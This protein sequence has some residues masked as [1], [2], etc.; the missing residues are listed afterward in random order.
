MCIT[1][2]S[3][4]DGSIELPSTDRNEWVI[5]IS[6]DSVAKSFKR[7]SWE[8]V[9]DFRPCTFR[10]VINESSTHTFSDSDLYNDTTVVIKEATSIEPKKYYLHVQ[11][12]S[13]SGNESGVKSVSFILQ[14]LIVMGV[15]D[16]HSILQSKTFNWKC[17][18]PPCTCR[19]T[20]NRSPTHTFSSRD[21]YEDMNTM[22]RTATSEQMEKHYLHVQVKD[23]AGTVSEV[24]SVSFL[25]QRLAVID[26]EN[27]GVAKKSKKF[28]WGC[29]RG[30]CQFRFAINESNLHVF[31]DSKAYEDNNTAIK[32][33]TTSYPKTYY[34]HVQA[35][36]LAGS[37]SEVKSVSFALQGLNVTGIANDSTSREFKIFEWSCS[38]APCTYRFTVNQ[39]PRYT[40]SKF[41]IYGRVNTL[42]KEAS[43]SQ[44]Q[45]YYLHV[46]AKDS[47]GHISEVKSVFFILQKLAVTGFEDDKIIKASKTL[48]WGCNRNRCTYRYAVNQSSSHTFSD[49]DLYSNTNVVIKEAA[50]LQPETYYLHVQ[51][52]DSSGNESEVKSGSFI[53]QKLFVT[54]IED[55]SSVKE[56]KT[57][58]WGCNLGRC[59]FRYAVTQSLTQIFSNNDSY[60]NV[61]T[62]TQATISPQVE[63]YYLHVQAKDSLGNESDIKSVSFTLR[64]LVVTGIES[65]AVPRNSKNLIWG[66]NADSC[67]F[68]F[69]VN[70][71]LT[72]AFS[73][74]DTY[75]SATVITRTATSDQTQT[76]YLHVQAKDSSGIESD[77]KSVSFILQ[78]L[79]VTGMRTEF[80]STKLFTDGFKTFTWG[81]NRAPCTFR[82]V[83]NQSETHT[84]SSNDSYE[85]VSTVT[86]V[87]TSSEVE[88]YYLHVQAKD[89][90]GEESDVMTASFFL[91]KLEVTG[92]ESETTPRNS[93][94]F[95]WGCNKRCTFRY[96]VN[97]SSTHT[98]SSSDTYGEVT[99]MERKAVSTQAETYYLHV[100][101][102]DG[103][104]DES[105]VKSVSFVLEKLEVTGLSSDSVAKVSKTFTWSCSGS[106]CEYRFVVNK[107]STHTFSATD[108]YGNTTT[109]TRMATSTQA[110]TYYL[111]V[112]AK[113][114]SNNESDVRS[115]SFVLQKLDVTGIASDTDA[116]VSKTFIWGCTLG[117][118]TYR[119]AV[120][121][122]STHT[123]SGTDAYGSTTTVIQAA[124]FTQ[125]ETYYLH[126]QAKDSSNN[127][128]DIKS[129]SFV[130]QGLAVIGLS[131]DSVAKVSKTFTWDCAP[132]MCT[133]RYVVNQSSTHTFTNG[134][135]YG[136]MT[137][138]TRSAT[139][140]QAETY[141]LH[142]QAKDASSNESEVKSVSFVLQ[143][144]SVTGLSIDSVAK[145]SKTFAWGCSLDFCTY[146]YVVN[147]SSSHTFTNGDAYGSTATVT[148]SATSTQAETYYLHVQAKDSSNNESDVKSVSFV[149][150][151]LSVTGLS[152]DSVAKVSKTFAWGCSLDFCTYRYVVNQSS[153]HTFTNGDAYG[154]T[155]TVTRSAT[156]TQAETYY[157][158]VQAKDSSNNES[159]VKSVSFVLQRLSVTGLSIDSVAK[160]SKTF[161]WN[162]APWTC[163][164]RYVV[165]QSSTHTFTNGDA[166]GS[167]ATVTRSATSTQAETYYLHVQAKDSLNNESDVKSVSFVL[168]GLAVTGL[169]DDSDAKVSKTFAWGCSLD[170]CT[171]RYVVNQ[172]ST[173]TFSASDTYDNIATVTRTA[174]STQ[175]ETYYLH[176]QAKDASSN[177]SEVKT[178]SFVLQGLSVI[179]IEDDSSATPSK[180]FT[181]DC[182]PGTC[183]YRYVVNQS[184]THTFSSTDSYGIVTTII[185][186]A[187]STQAETYY[188]H[189][190]AKDSLNNE[191]DVKS[192][193]FVLQGLAV[194]DLSSDSDAK[195]SKTFTWDCAPG[196]CTYRYVVN[197][198]S[199]HTFTNGDA[200]GS[201]ATVTRSATSTQ[202]ETYYLHVQAKDSLN[203]ESDVKS[204]SFVLQGLAV[205]DLSSD[206][207]AKVSK[208]FTWDCAPGTCTYRYVVNQS[209]THT[210]SDSDS[211]GIVTTIIRTASSAQTET[212][213]L[214]VQAKDTSGNESEVKSVLFVLQGLAVTGLSDDNDVKVSKTFTWDCAPEACTYRYVVNQSSTHTFS[215]SDIYDSTTTITRTASSNTSETYYL[216]VQAKDSS[217]NESE[218]KSVSFVLQGLAVT[219]LSSDSDAKVSKT[220]TWD[221]VPGTCT[222]RY[223]VNQSSTHTFS[224][225]DTYD[226]ITTVTRTAS[227]T[228]AETYYLHIQA[229]DTSGNESEVKSVSFILQVL[230]VTGIESDSDVKVSKTF[231]WGCSL[232][233]CT[234]RYVVNQSSTHTFTNGD[235][236]G[237]TATVTRTASSN[238]SETYYLHVQT[239]DSSSNES[240]VKSVSFVLQNLVVTGIENDTTVR[241]FKQF[242]WG[243]NVGPCA[244]RF[245]VGL[246]STYRFP[247]SHR[248]SSN[249]NNGLQRATSLTPQRLYLHVQAKD[250]LGNESEVKSVSFVLQGLAVTDLSSDS[251]AKVSK[252]F[253]W[254]CAPGTCTYRYVVN[255]SSSHTF[256]NGDA[257]GST[258]TVTRSATS[259]QAET[260]YLHVQAKDSLNNESDV[261]SVSF[262]LQGLA[263]INIEDDSTPTPSKTFT[264]GCSFDSCTYRYVVNQSSTHTFSESDIYDST[265]MVTRT[266]TSTQSETYYLHVQSKD[267]A[268]NVSEVK[269]VSFIL[270]GL[271]V[272]GLSNDNDAKVSK[273]FT[274]SCAPGTCTYRYVVN[275][276]STHTFT[277]G[278]SYGSTATVTRSATSIQAETY[279]LHVQ[280][281]DT[282]SNESEV[283]TVSFLLQGLSVIDIED[284][285]FATS[286]KIFIWNCA[287]GTCTYRYVVNQSSTHTFTNGDAYGS[288]ATVTR[289]ATSTQAETYYLHVQAKDASSNESEVKSVSFVLQGL[290]VTGIESDN[291]A[292]ASKTF[293][294]SCE[295]GTCTYRYA[296]NQS[297]THTFTNG[298]AYGSIATATFTATSMQTET[299]Y[300]HVQAK[301]SLNNESDVKSVLFV[302]QGLA[303]TGIESDTDA[304]ASKTFT[305]GCNLGP[306][307][308]RYIIN[309]SLSHTFTNGDAYGS[310]ETVTPTATSTQAETYYLHV[311]VK[312]SSNH[313]SEVKTIFFILQKLFVTGIESDNV[314]KASKTFTWGCNLGPCTF[315]YAVNQSVTH[316]FSNSDAYGNTVTVTEA[317]ISTQIE[318][319]YLHV[320]AKDSSNNESEVKSVLFI[321]QQLIVEGI[322]DDVS[323]Q[324]I[325][326]FNWSCNRGSPCT[327]R[328]VI[329]QSSTHMFSSS[330][331]Y[332]SVTTV[333]ELAI[334]EDQEIYYLHVQAKDL[335]NNESE[336]KSVSFV[337]QA[338][339][340]TAAGYNFSCYLQNSTGQ[341]KCWGYNTQGQLGQGDTDH[342]GIE[343]NQMGSDLPFIDLGTDRT[344]KFIAANYYHACA[345]LDNDS[346]KCWGRNSKGQL[347]LGDKENRGD[348]ANEMGD[349]LS[350][351]N[352]GTGRTAKKVALGKEHTCA[353]LDNGSVKCWGKNNK[354]QL[355]L[356]DKNYRGDGSNKM[357]DNL[358]VVNLG[359]GRTA[360]DIRAGKDHTCVLL[361]NDSLKCWGENG[362]GQLGLGDN[363]NRG[364]GPNE[365]GDNLP[366]VN[367]GANRIIKAVRAGA[368]NTCV[369]LQN[370]ELICWGYN[371][372]GQLGKGH[373][374]YVGARPGEIGST[375]L[376]IDLGTGRTVRRVAVGENNICAILDNQSVKCWGD[377]SDGG[378]GLGD[379]ESRGDESNE[380][381]DNLPTVNL[382]T[383]LKAKDIAAGRSHVCVVLQ[384]DGIKCWGGGYYGQLGQEHRDDIGNGP[385]EMGDNLPFT[386]L[387]SDNNDNDND[388]DDDDDD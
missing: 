234:Y 192:V 313:E 312:N 331:F 176:V 76:Y 120:N 267:P 262:V 369:I 295:P 327:Y 157:L 88:T 32:I 222:Y 156:S 253:T 270:Q 144:L 202:A 78:Q 37:E 334:I 217:S 230:A 332:S 15:G 210:F 4:K 219:D 356:G 300:L 17:N 345:I 141:Y 22:S 114:L 212:Y 154:S 337:L 316:T 218:V 179:N 211:Y 50:S 74:R 296:V 24:K 182:R 374:N 315:R 201:T 314:T 128:S 48:R 45:R 150:Q 118:C 21:P 302:L 61:T 290:S 291:V 148:R 304:K 75:G 85:N 112:Q 161:T 69:V 324:E 276:S 136:S 307:T 13:E 49:R 351:V 82:F 196:T 29:N 247:Q 355:G 308:Y 43:S 306:C 266:A 189:V 40:F 6:N 265:T 155:A 362:F 252:T 166:Y 293:N 288:T 86:K 68:R 107:S 132:W 364:D 101:A 62:I 31:S 89:S 346:L 164:Y 236:Y 174:V 38:D 105:E 361:D 330:D 133:Y 19:A 59:T 191:S 70:Q 153:S 47:E 352:L 227:S 139:S 269:T 323:I 325:K 371:F 354:G 320:Q 190:Q 159:D 379:L 384:D 286:S 11:A 360:K 235:A 326:T 84:F 271:A 339:P 335:S 27:D 175:A 184:S 358:P 16:D 200:Y 183:T 298:D 3:N 341:V 65:D 20:I 99:R 338:I 376:A 221:C 382:G 137:T 264:W 228:Q 30:T 113:D 244:F 103:L 257:Y 260:Y 289:S 158:H 321:L 340:S 26:I 243:C 279:Y 310:T 333:T 349:N 284:D 12:R 123:F 239:K 251:D 193:S 322:E 344:V 10:H 52:K 368:E 283:K 178:V 370:N 350:T 273:A 142:V 73:S 359:M 14:R 248:Y 206:S 77:V 124:N 287:P 102:K 388:D 168:Q 208:T 229:K 81:C 226:N 285:S 160:V 18:N 383:G 46:Q 39:S 301:D 377:N 5:G 198:S 378:L 92:I 97:T 241:V 309:Q 173:H 207:D 51:A 185:R 135:A 180:M 55:D 152:I 127:E 130:L 311:Q 255:Q 7:F 151:R 58:K 274:W 278:D 317:A 79:M 205:T 41:D 106:S 297:M 36:D 233:S 258:A 163:T 98:F 363:N 203:N 223:V 169:E 96:A 268:N 72:H 225:S 60:G 186:T 71:S 42:T 215:E 83:M 214:H 336:V 94:V 246:H 171:Y 126:V 216:H 93:K 146:R 348:D 63:N 149:L 25:L 386:D 57:F 250:T 375:L 34:L 242:Y 145:V 140:T 104:G 237:S 147:Q 9:S 213:Y 220:F 240:A 387:F 90:S 328:Y 381:G 188:L 35:R 1:G 143:G 165:N 263:V 292:K 281:K 199:S 373:K 117:S 122:S 204:V 56:P 100:Q 197:Q 119:Y 232:D 367:L 54:G 116:K 365:M 249:F 318:T 111:H 134:D 95:E 53:L 343:P 261:K 44:A 109:V 131:S 167:T 294:W 282:S 303:V 108:T 209:S 353:I 299:Y 194:T 64:K 28:T 259:T 342:R 187:T 66:C 129:V 275:Q 195:V 162:C 357:G 224:D 366:V 8:C 172:S 138:V 87:P 231:T 380:M 80:I 372:Y 280:A 125:A 177:E 305:W 67:E 254:D 2:C 170:F 238:T 319:Y 329:N 277:N 272:T 181:W 121:Q 23:A 385:D 33:A 245:S 256:T 110:E 115:A 91:Q 347:G